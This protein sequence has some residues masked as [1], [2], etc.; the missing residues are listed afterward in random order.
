VAAA[1]AA[2]SEV[3]IARVWRGA[4][5]RKERAVKNGAHGSRACPRCRA[6]RRLQLRLPLLF[7]REAA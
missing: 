4:D 6:R 5:R 1:V 7:G 3:T 2:G